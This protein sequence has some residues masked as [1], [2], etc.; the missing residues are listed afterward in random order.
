MPRSSS[1]QSASKPMV[2]QRPSFPMSSVKPFRMS[3]PRAP[4]PISSPVPSSSSTTGQLIKDS[5]ISGVGSGIGFSAGSRLMN[6][7]FGPTSLVGSMPQ[8]ETQ[9]QQQQKP[10]RSPMERCVEQMALYSSREDLSLC[11]NLL[12]EDMQYREFQ[13]CMKTSNNDGEMCKNYLP[14]E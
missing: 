9:N 14:T 12:K 11:L 7:I 13:Q 5:I 8:S 1:N 10:H 3:T 6:S 4:V 2:S